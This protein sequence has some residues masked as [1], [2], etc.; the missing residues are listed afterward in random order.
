[1]A[2]RSSRAD[3][4]FAVLLALALAVGVLLWLYYPVVPRSLLGWVLLFVV[5]IPTWFFLEW[6]GD[7]VLGAHV[8]SRFGP[9]A[10]IALAVPLL[11]LLLLVAAYVIH[12]GQRAISGS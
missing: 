11:I 10:R 7:R 8:F 9:A 2:F 6:V 12:L 4:A 1:M 3:A 5:G